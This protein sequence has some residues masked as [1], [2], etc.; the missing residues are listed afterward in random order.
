M[1]SQGGCA[2]T[3]MTCKAT[4]KSTQMTAQMNHAQEELNEQSD[5]VQKK[6]NDGQKSMQGVQSAMATHLAVANATF[7]AAT[8]NASKAMACTSEY[9]QCSSGCTSDPPSL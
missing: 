7:N 1:G 4:C 9:T 2:T 8:S 5:L 6:L 3:L